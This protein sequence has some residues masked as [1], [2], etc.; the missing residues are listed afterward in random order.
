MK[1]AT[2]SIL[3]LEEAFE[4]GNFEF[5]EEALQEFAEAGVRDSEF[6]LTVKSN[7]KGWDA[8]SNF[9]SLQM[10]TDIVSH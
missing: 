3:S 2:S 1:N 10:F 4:D 7:L 5:V 8:R 6:F 9:K